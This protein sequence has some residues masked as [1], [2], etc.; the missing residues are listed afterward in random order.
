MQDEINEKCVMLVI[1][2]GKI[3]ERILRDAIT[4]SMRWMDKNKTAINR[5]ST[6]R[7]RIS[8]RRLSQRGELSNIE[9]T[10]K[11]IRAFESTAR[12]YG[13]SYALKKDRSREP[14]RYLVFFKAKDAAQMEAAFKEFTGRTMHRKRDRLSIRSRLMEKMAE[15]REAP[16]KEKTQ[17]RERDKGR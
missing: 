10:S 7:G 3:S 13:V 6:Y 11:N 8:I 16:Q 12:K 15:S 2:G 17:Q 5:E 9:I 4:Q 14:P 1:N